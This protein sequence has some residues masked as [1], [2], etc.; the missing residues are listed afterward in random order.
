MTRETLTLTDPLRDYLVAHSVRDTPLLTRL[1]AE[2]ETL[3]KAAGW[4]ISPEQGQLMALLVEATGTRRYLEV[5]CFTGYSALVA[6]LAMPP[7]G[8]VVTCDIVEDFTTIARRYWAEAGVADRIDL[9]MGP[10]LATLDDLLV[11][12]AGADSFDMAFIDADKLHYVEY[13]EHCLKLVRPGGLIL[14]D[15][16]LWRGRVVAPADQAADVRAIRALND[17]IATDDRVTP[18]MVPIGDG[19]TIVRRRR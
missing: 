9:R 15:N 2:T 1:R 8:R 7:D 19:L 18:A 13:Y 4:Q 12:A 3:G 10:A 6:A 14:V 17:S 16:V 5:G 11:R